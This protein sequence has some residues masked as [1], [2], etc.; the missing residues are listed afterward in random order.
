MPNPQTQT[1]Q[2]TNEFIYPTNPTSQPQPQPQQFYHQQPPVQ[3]NNYIPNLY[4]NT[5]NMTTQ[6]INLYPNSSQQNQY[7]HQQQTYQ[8]TNQP[9]YN[10]A[11]NQ[12]IPPQQNNNWAF[13]PN[14]QNQYMNANPVYGQTSPQVGQTTQSTNQG[15]SLSNKKDD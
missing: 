13:N 5:P 15:I 12:H 14:P 10:Q 6:N 11:Y 4:G 1:Q 9:A 7:Q 2:K 3:N 8:P